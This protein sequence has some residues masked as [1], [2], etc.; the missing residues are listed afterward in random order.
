MGRYGA[1]RHRIAGCLLLHITWSQARAVG[2]GPHVSPH[3]CHQ[4]YSRWRWNFAQCRGM[5]APTNEAACEE[6]SHKSQIQG[7]HLTAAPSFQPPSIQW[8]RASESGCP[9][10]TTG[11]SSSCRK[12]K[13]CSE[14]EFTE[15][16]STVW[17]QH[18]AG[19]I[20]NPSCRDHM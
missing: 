9:L 2:A 16:H 1:P 12:K 5:L 10:H 6:H 3:P 13:D 17:P 20:A 4:L 18:V 15:V 19:A 7:L 8:I 14:R 11:P